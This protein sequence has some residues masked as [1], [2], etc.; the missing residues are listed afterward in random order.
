M[1]TSTNKYKLTKPE[2]S[3][4]VQ[5]EVLNAN[6]DLI[7]SALNDLQ[8]QATANKNK[9]DSA[10]QS[11]QNHIN[12]KN[13]PHGMTKGQL[14]LGNVENKSSATIR[15]ELTKN[16]VTNALGYTPYTPNEVDNKLSAL[17]TKIDWKEAVD[18]FNDIATI[19]PS[20]HDGWTVNVKDTDYTY[21]YDGDKWVVISAN[22]IPKATQ[23]VDGLLSKED[24]ANYDD[25]N[26]KKHTHNNKSILDKITQSLLDNW[27]AAYTH[28]SDTVKHISSTERTNWTDAYN[29]RHTH[30]NKSVLDEITSNLISACNNAVEH[31]TDTTKHITNVERTL[32][33]TVAD[34]VDKVNGKGLSTNDYT[35]A[36]KEKL[37]DIEDGAEVNVQPDWNVTDSTNDAFIKNKPESMPASNTV[38]DYSSTGTA[39]VNG[40][41]V[42]KALQTLDVASKGGSGKYIQSISE[43][44]GKI[45][46]VEA[47]MP[48]IPTKTSQLT[49]DS[50]YKTTDNNT[51][52]ANTKDSEGYVAKGTGHA[53]QVWSTD[54]NG[55][56]AWREN[57]I[58]NINGITDSI[59]STA[60]DIAASANA[61]K[62]L[63]DKITQL[64]SNLSKLSLLVV[65]TRSIAD[66]TPIAVDER[67]T[68]ATFNLTKGNWLIF[69][70]FRL[71]QNSNNARIYGNSYPMT[72]LSGS[73]NQYSLNVDDS[74]YANRIQAIQN[75]N[76]VNV[77]SDTAVIIN[78]CNLFSIGTIITIGGQQYFA[79][80]IG[81]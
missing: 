27:N 1:A 22:A 41:A 25:A 10:T 72:V 39:P 24:K 11:L 7:D 48:T 54:A 6:M 38:S 14:G 80:K 2:L 71:D 34:K 52:K 46:A 33:N 20:P 51:W 31:I 17:E 65:G 75:I 50:G 53:N 15:G 19:Y 29:K 44:D 73:A 4:K 3:E 74:T 61:V 42:N 40:I 32:W 21:R 68:F 12:D 67:P 18:T 79:I 16:N 55:N 76:Y 60:S 30:D 36:E 13:N 81:N 9:V 77:T 66:A 47:T 69:S 8:N 26:S 70:S 56:P 57:T 62:T 63:N 64:N 45:S 23:S 78:N 28:I 59:T 58:A 35:T 5:V 43:T 49:N 37:R